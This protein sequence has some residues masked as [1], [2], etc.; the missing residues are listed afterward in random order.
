MIEVQPQG[1]SLSLLSPSR[2][3][4]LPFSHF[5]MLPVLGLDALCLPFSVSCFWRVFALSIACPLPSN[6]HVPIFMPVALQSATTMVSRAPFCG[7]CSSSLTNSTIDHTISPKWC[8]WKGFP[9]WKFPG[10]HDSVWVDALLICGSLEG[11][12]LSVTGRVW[13]QGISHQDINAHIA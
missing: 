8:R 2:I 4:R 13:Y 3:N 6:H 11:N 12:Y 5:K 9:T 10:L 7:S 1:L